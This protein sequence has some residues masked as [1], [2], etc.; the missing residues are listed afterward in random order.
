MAGLLIYTQNYW[1]EWSSAHRP[2]GLDPKSY[3]EVKETSVQSIIEKKNTVNH[4]N[5]TQNMLHFV[6]ANALTK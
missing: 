6:K 2:C 1:C 3:E 5:L 4:H